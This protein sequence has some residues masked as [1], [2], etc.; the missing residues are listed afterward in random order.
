MLKLLKFILGKRARKPEPMTPERAAEIAEA[1]KR[2][3]HNKKVLA[4]RPYGCD[5]FPHKFDDGYYEVGGLWATSFCFIHSRMM[6]VK[7]PKE[8]FAGTAEYNGATQYLRAKNGNYRDM[9][10][11]EP[12]LNRERLS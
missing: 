8:L 12:G 9:K 1:K 6:T 3:E 11:G 4:M 10:P 7:A 5:C 2:Y